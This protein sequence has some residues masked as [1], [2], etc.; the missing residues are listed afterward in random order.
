MPPALSIASGQAPGAVVAADFNGDGKVDLAVGH[1]GMA[2]LIGPNGPVFFGWI[3]QSTL[4]ILRGRGNGT[5]TRAGVY[6]VAG[7]P[8]DLA[9]GDANE[10]GKPDLAVACIDGSGTPVGKLS[11]LLNNGSGGFAA[12]TPITIGQYATSVR[13]LNLNPGTGT[14]QDEHLDLAVTKTVLDGDPMETSSSVMTFLGDGSGGFGSPQTK[15]LARYGQA[16]FAAPGDLNEDGLDDLVVTQLPGAFS[17]LPSL[18]DG[19]L[20]TEI[21]T[22]GMFIPRSV[23]VAD[24]DGDSHLDVVL[25]EDFEDVMRAYRG[26]GDGTLQAPRAFLPEAVPIRVIHGDWNG[27]NHP[28]LATLDAA[29]GAVK[30]FLG[31][32]S[33]S[34]V[35]RW[36]TWGSAPGLPGPRRP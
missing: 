12:Q 21:Q 29:T 24:F 23:A 14:G 26:N 19:T 30:A 18:G 15:P 4:E 20:G 10:D 16:W 2:L 9:A 11:L 1:T 35:G 8:F 31:G 27:D 34:S 22:T 33:G 7:A 6:A 32:S 3:Y 5:F 17:V 28:D 13:F 25:T 36:L